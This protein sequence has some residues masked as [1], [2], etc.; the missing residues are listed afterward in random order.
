[1]GGVRNTNKENYYTL[2]W[3]Q[4]AYMSSQAF[5]YIKKNHENGLSYHE[6]LTALK[7]FTPM[8]DSEEIYYKDKNIWRRYLKLLY[9]YLAEIYQNERPKNKIE[10][11]K[12][13]Q[14]RESDN[15]VSSKY[16]LYRF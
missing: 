12:L 13:R 3:E 11:D 6:C 16:F 5:N 14:Q 4:D 10:S 15:D 1:L 9:F 2:P 8:S 7:K